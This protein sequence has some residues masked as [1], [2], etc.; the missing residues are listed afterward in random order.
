[1]TV[2]HGRKPDDNRRLLSLRSLVILVIAA[3]SGIAVYSS[4]GGIDLVIAT[5]VTVAAGLHSLVGW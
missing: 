2:R 3:G 5:V 1:M 4:G